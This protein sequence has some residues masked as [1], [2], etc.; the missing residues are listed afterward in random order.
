MLNP[1][2]I[3]ICEEAINQFSMAI[4][5]DSNYRSAYEKRGYCY[6]EL[7]VLDLALDNY[8]KALSIDE[9]AY[10]YCIIGYTYSLLEDYEEAIIAFEAGIALDEE[11]NYPWCVIY[12]E[13][14][15][16]KTSTP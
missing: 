8:L 6:L 16:L 14:A 11:G 5:L 9:D 15:K 7:G 13:D 3:N 4:D 2:N 1:R 12:L 10:I